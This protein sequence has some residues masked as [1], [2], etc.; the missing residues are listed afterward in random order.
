MTG[1]ASRFTVAA[2]FTLA[3]AIHAQDIDFTTSV[4]PIFHRKC[5]GCHS[6]SQQMNGVRLDDRSAALKGGYSGPVITPGDANSSKLVTRI[7]SEKD[8][9]RMPP[10][11][12][13]LT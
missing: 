6:A 11:G 3:A 12:A 8:G 4:E 13:R 2:F 9:F 5:Y 1:L 7:S 10:A